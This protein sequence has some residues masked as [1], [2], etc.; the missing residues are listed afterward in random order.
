MTMRANPLPSVAAPRRADLPRS[1]R[2]LHA[3]RALVLALVA[4]ALLVGPGGV[5]VAASPQPSHAPRMQ[6]ARFGGGHSFGGGRGFGSGRRGLFGGSRHG[7]LR[8]VVHALTFAYL[9]HLLFTTPL[10]WVLLLIVAVLLFRLTRG[11][12]RAYR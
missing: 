3:I 10:G 11:R 7:L 1:R 8:H 9:L 2:A 6:L 5:A 4:G 12:R